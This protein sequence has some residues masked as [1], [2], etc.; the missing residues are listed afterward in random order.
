MFLTDDPAATLGFLGLD[1]GP[2]G[3][4]E[5]ASEAALFG[6]LAGGRFMRR[7]A[8][9]RVGLRANDRKRVGKR[10]M[11]RRFV[12]EW[13]LGWE[14]G[15]EEEEEGVGLTREEV[16]EEALERFGKR[17]EYVE[18]VERWEAER[19]RLGEKREG[20]EERKAQALADEEYADAWV[21]FIK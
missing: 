21:R 8:Y 18:R 7:G 2:Y 4:G 15:A 9:E 3:A 19:R 14:G 5:F 13:V 1:A 10:E 16:L 17:G 6:Y 12:E 11:Y 20:R